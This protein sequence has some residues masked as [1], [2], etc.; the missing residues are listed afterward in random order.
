MELRAMPWH[1]SVIESELS[2]SKVLVNATSV[3]LASDESPILAE[4]LP[5]ELLVM[6]L[7]YNPAETRL[8][9]DARA[10][11]AAGTQNGEPMLLA[12]G[13]AAFELWTGQPA[14]LDVMRAGLERARTIATEEAPGTEISAADAADGVGTARGGEAAG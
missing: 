11:G 8:L 4:L 3:G 12:Q 5:P 2:K 1:D 6:D 10:A 7:I 14:P 9:R 13:A